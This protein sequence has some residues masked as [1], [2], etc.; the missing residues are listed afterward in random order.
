[1]GGSFPATFHP[2]EA[3]LVRVVAGGAGASS[4]PALLG[5]LG[6]FAANLAG[7]S[8]LQE[9]AQAG[10]VVTALLGALTVLLIWRLLRETL[11]ATYALF[12]AAV[13]AASPLLVASAHYFTPDTLSLLLGATG[14]LCLA[15]ALEER[16]PAWRFGLGATVGLALSTHYGGALLLVV[17]ALAPFA[18][19]VGDV[20]GWLR[21]M[22]K[23]AAVALAVFCLTNVALLLDPERLRHG[24]WQQLQQLAVGD[25]LYV[26]SLATGAAFH[27]MNTLLPGLTAP[28]LVAAVCGF[29]VAISMRSSLPTSG[30]LLFL[31][32]ALGF[33]VAELS[34]LKPLPGAERYMLP[35]LPGAALAA[36][37]ALQ[38]LDDRIARRSLRWI[39]SLMMAAVL[40]PPAYL[41]LQLTR[42]LANDT[43]LH[44][45]AWIAANTG[46]ALREAHSSAATPDVPSIATID[47]DAA[48]RGG[49]THVA[50]SSFVYDTFA[51][52]SRLANQHEYVYERHERYQALFEYPYVEFR[53]EYPR[54]GWSQPTIRILDIREPR[55]PGRP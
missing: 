19:P 23:A 55:P 5:Q 35:V 31:Y 24:P 2:D 53:P 51:R 7:A 8:S 6:L 43:R 41:S 13:A 36:G 22:G 25:H 27:L 18:H 40:L 29:A 54:L 11:R 14:I 28:V 12:G 17:C 38:T 46:R 16:T 3:A 45:D 48:R 52:G 9:I 47:L 15:R 4:E 49:V 30:R 32:G 34:P 50:T 44:A 33:V 39:P 42:G 26:T 1:M 20:R 37:L 21:E 10:R